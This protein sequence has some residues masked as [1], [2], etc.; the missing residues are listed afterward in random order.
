MILDE[1]YARYDIVYPFQITRFRSLIEHHWEGEYT[2]LGESHNFWEFICVLDGE[3]E[4]VQDGKIHLLKS[5]NFCCC[6]PMAFHS[7]CNIG[8]PSHFLNFSFEHIGTLPSV[9]SGGVFYLTP[10]EIDEVKS[11]FY[12][13]EEAFSKEP[14]DLAM[15]AEAASAMT[16]FLLRLSRQHTPHDR[17]AK[18]RSGVMYQKLV[19]TMRD[20]LYENLSVQEI[21]ARNAIGI[22]TMKEL[23]RKYSGIG[24][25]RYYAEM[26]GI[27]ALRL[28]EAGMEIVEITEKLNYSSPNYFSHCFKKQFGAPPGQYRKGC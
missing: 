1:L 3:I 13:L 9:L 20:A 11:I 14:A 10:V 22:T 24:P 21:A 25:K 17:L 19:E 5:G 2:F 16:S 27:E 12:R 7:S 8:P 18:T 15:G 4:S 26:R 23:F 28:L 6:P